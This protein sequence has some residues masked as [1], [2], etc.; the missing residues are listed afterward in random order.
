MGDFI[1]KDMANLVTEMQR[2]RVVVRLPDQAYIDIQDD[3]VE[4]LIAEIESAK[5]IQPT[6]KTFD[7]QLDYDN[8]R[9]WL[10]NYYI[11]EKK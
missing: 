7:I 8:L 3:L 9:E 6:D 5:L 10:R 11:L 1:Q 2:D 4:Q